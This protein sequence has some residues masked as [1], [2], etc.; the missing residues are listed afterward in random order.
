MT[1]GE[2]T[3]AGRPGLTGR[4]APWRDRLR[5]RPTPPR[6]AFVLS[7]GGNLGALQV[8]MLRALLEHRILPDLVLGC[9]VGALNGVALAAEPSLATV[10]RLQDMWLELD[11]HDVLPGG[12]L[13]T[14]V[15]MARKGVAVH[16]NAGIRRVVEAVLEVERFED[17]R[18]PF[19]CVATDVE[20]AREVWFSEGPL[21]EP[22]LAS[23][24]LPA[25]LPPVEVDGVRYIDGAVVNDVP[26]S[27]AVELG[28]TTI[29]VLHVGGFD[30]PRPEPKR[31]FDMALQ[32]YWI[33]RRARFRRDMAALPPSVDAVLLPTG[34]ARWGRFND[35]RHSAE[36]MASSYRATDALLRARAEGEGAGDEEAA[37]APREVP[38]GEVLGTESGE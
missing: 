25:V 3:A 37:P 9:S 27:R 17:L 2:P 7:G 23:S 16:G 24:A 18:V 13:P 4:L 15:Q 5:R 12:L 20:A 33:A 6:T 38:E 19:Q 32:A 22:I 31:P 30:R 36:M 28:A 1:D 8:G 11:D 29:Y 34:D 26:V 10:G 14:T 35:F 21:V